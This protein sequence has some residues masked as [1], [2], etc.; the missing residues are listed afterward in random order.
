MHLNF[1]DMVVDDPKNPTLM[2]IRLKLSKTD[3]FCNEV[4]IFL[5][6]TKNQL[7][8]IEAML[9]FLAVRGD[10]KGFLFT[11]ADGSLLT[12][13]RFITR[14]R[15]VLQKAGVDSKQYSGHSFHNNGQHARHR[16]RDH[17]DAWKMAKHSILVLRKDTQRPTGK[18]VSYNWSHARNGHKQRQ[19]R[20]SSTV[21]E[22]EPLPG[23]ML[24]ENGL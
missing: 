8:P 6:R 15:Q 3:P 12:K 21:L 1:A 5:G 17:Q 16:R 11:F 18:D 9:A 22:I 14:V 24:K 23:Y 20:N 4:D 13:G 7:C 10:K 19:H 2:R